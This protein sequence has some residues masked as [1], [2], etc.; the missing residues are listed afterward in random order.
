MVSAVV[1]AGYRKEEVEDYKH[2]LELGYKE[3]EFVE[4]YKP[5]KLLLGKPLIKYTLEK[6]ENI[7][8]VDDIVIVGE[9]DLLEREIGEWLQRNPKPFKIVD[10]NDEIDDEL[11]DALNIDRNNMPNNSFCGNAVKAYAVTDAY[12]RRDPALFMVSDSPLTKEEGI[13]YFIE[14]AQKQNPKSS[15]VYPIASMV[16]L[17]FWRKAFHRKYFFLINDTKYK[18]RGSFKTWFTKR[19]GFRISAI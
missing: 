11:V 4:G 18:Y 8:S 10:Q 1:M 17:P 12:E 7:A 9:K 13:E 6:L 5:L 15:L 19:E 16:E 2:Q 14:N 3:E